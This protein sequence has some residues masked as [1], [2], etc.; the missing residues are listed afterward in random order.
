M[1]GVHPTMHESGEPRFFRKYT[2]AALNYKHD[3]PINNVLV[4]KH[5]PKP[6]MV[7]ICGPSKGGSTREQHFGQVSLLEIRN[8]VMPLQITHKQSCECMR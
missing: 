5:V 8:S 6:A 7:E 1:G 2:T 3:H 4:L